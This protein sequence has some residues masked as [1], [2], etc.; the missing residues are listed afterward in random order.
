MP[1]SGVNTKHGIDDGL[2][3]QFGRRDPVATTA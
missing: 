3:R 2:R 1:I